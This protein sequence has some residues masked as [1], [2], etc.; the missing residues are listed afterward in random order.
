MAKA[1]DILRVLNDLEPVELDGLKFSVITDASSERAGTGRMAGQI[2]DTGEPSFWP[3]SK[4]EI[5]INDGDGGREPF[6][7]GRKPAKW[8]VHEES[9]D[10]LAEALEC[11]RKVLA[12]EWPRVYGEAS[13]G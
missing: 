5:I 6:G 7:E 1:E 11:R 10:T 12:G 4:G 8:D 2:V 3:F 13:R 9:F